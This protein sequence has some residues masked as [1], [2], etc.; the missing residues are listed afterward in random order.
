MPTLRA[1]STSFMC[2]PAL[3]TLKMTQRQEKNQFITLSLVFLPTA[4]KLP[5]ALYFSRE[6]FFPSIFYKIA[7]SLLSHLLCNCLFHWNSFYQAHQWQVILN[8]H[9]TRSAPDPGKHILIVPHVLNTVNASSVSKPATESWLV[10]IQEFCEPWGES[11]ASKLA[12]GTSL[13]LYFFSEI[14]FTSTLL[15]TV[16]IKWYMLSKYI[17]LFKFNKKCNDLKSHY[18]DETKNTVC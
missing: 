3:W 5:L 11:V 10:N 12:N 18:W 9:L 1:S 15:I 2:L 6:R 13:G 4:P 14:L 7:C 16:S 17:Q 8:F